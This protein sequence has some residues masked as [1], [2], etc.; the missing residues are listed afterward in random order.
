MIENRVFGSRGVTSCLLITVTIPYFK[1]NTVALYLVLT[2]TVMIN[3][4]ISN[5]STV[6]FTLEN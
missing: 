1:H 2:S 3:P 4:I 5:P 6:M